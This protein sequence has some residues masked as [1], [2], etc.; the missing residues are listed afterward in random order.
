[1]KKIEYNIQI[2]PDGT[3]VKNDRVRDEVMKMFHSKGST[4]YLTMTFFGADKN[5]TNDQNAYYWA[6]VV[7]MVTAGFIMQGNELRIGS[8]RDYE[9]V[10]TML[11]ERFI[12][13][14]DMVFFDRNGTKYG[15]KEKTTTALDT[16]AF[17]KYLKDIK[18]WTFDC[19]G[20]DIP[21]PNG[22][23]KLVGSNNQIYEMSVE[24]FLESVKS[25]ENNV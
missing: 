14:G 21:E 4:T 16:R 12:P 22:M 8:N 10:H 19:L 13:E 6:V 23:V 9:M 15:I 24:E 2:N 3:W 17:N 20:V 11:K 1:M 5:R 7:P 25:N 18:T